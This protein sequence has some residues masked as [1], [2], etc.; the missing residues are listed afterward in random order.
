MRI[1]IIEDDKKTASFIIRGFRELGFAVNHAADGDEG[2]MMGESG[3]Y[4]V[5]IVD[6]MLPALDGLSVIKS[7]RRNNTSIKIIILSAKHSLD[8]KVKGLESGA[9][10]YLTKPFAFA[11]LCARVNA[12]LRRN[13]QSP[14]S[15]LLKYADLEMD[16]L[17]RKV[18]RGN[19]FIDL[20]PREYSLL[21]YMM[22]NP[23][24]VITR[25]MILEHVWD[26]NFDPATNVVDV[27]VCRLR[28]KIDRDFPVKLI[29]TVRGVGYVIREKN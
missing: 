29:H 6:L 7:I 14:S 8:E 3:D 12:L 10:D 23:N 4:D 27:L 2:L 9:D 28:D 19:I 25:I 15:A 21:E 13:T 22:R 1:L 26:I 11:E 24:R 16:L 17:S 20:Q 18:R 5:L